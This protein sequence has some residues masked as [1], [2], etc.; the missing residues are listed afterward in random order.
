MP[1]EVKPLRADARRN[2]D[3]LTAAALELFA[4]GGGDV[5]LEAVA[6]RAGV[7]VG[8]LYRH[9]A[10]REELVEA[11]Y[12]AELERLHE[13]AAELLAGHEPDEA[14]AL[15]MDNFVD[16]AVTKRGLSTAL[17]SVVASG[18]NPYSESRAKITAALRSLLEA[19]QCAGRVRADADP[20]DVLRAMGMIWAMPSGEPDFQERGKRMLGLLMDGLRYG[21]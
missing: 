21:A 12:R 6:K 11:A 15:W 8:T 1:T 13:S 9:F 16:Y 2:R 14:L 7:G 18:S 19:A 4:D 17:Q 3:K 20:E 5:P 10:S